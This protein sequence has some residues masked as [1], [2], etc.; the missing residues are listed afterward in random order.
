MITDCDSPC[1]L[2]T[3][4]AVLLFSR[5]EASDFLAGK[6]HQRDCDQHNQGLAIVQYPFSGTVDYDE[7]S[8]PGGDS[9]LARLTPERGGQVASGG[10]TSS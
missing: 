4:P 10:D 9:F 1:I 6:R 3:L 8:P 5:P 2:P 7:V